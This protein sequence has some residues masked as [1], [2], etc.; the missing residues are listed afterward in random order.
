MINDFKSRLP[1][2]TV[3]GGMIYEKKQ[4]ELI[5]KKTGKEVPVE[6]CGELVGYFADI[7]NYHNY[8][9]L[10]AKDVKHIFYEEFNEA[11][12]NKV[13]ELYFKFINVLKTF[14][15]FNNPWI[16]MLG[17]KDSNRNDFYVNWDIRVNDDTKGNMIQ[18]IT[19]NSG[20]LVGVW[21]DL[22]S[23]NFED[24]KNSETTADELASLDKK[25]A[26]YAQGGYKDDTALTVMSYKR[27][28]DDFEYKMRLGIQGYD[29]L[30]GKIKDT[31]CYAMIR[32][33]NLDNTHLEPFTKKKLIT[34]D[35]L[36]V[37]L[38][39]APKIMDYDTAIEFC[40]HL[41]LLISN[42][43]LIFD[44]YEL[45]DVI[46]GY[47]LIADCGILEQTEDDFSK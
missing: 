32:C 31:E 38:D 25:T 29:L 21:Y 19:S 1:Q 22:G 47:K 36:S 12:Y 8:K 46:K 3:K 44:S 2:F 11:N 20:K 39:T 35:A 4:E 15:R 42:N 43:R 10:E 5:N 40:K 14:S 26:R 34:V 27:I 6:K 17:N 18:E 30:Y 9:S 7:A 13:T 28:I 37:Y 45:M 33:L 41:F 24:L 16:Y 23:D